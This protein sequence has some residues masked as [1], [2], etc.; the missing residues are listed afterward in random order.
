MLGPEHKVARAPS[1]V[2]TRS[3][4]DPYALPLPACPRPN[5]L[6]LPA[7]AVAIVVPVRRAPAEA[8][9]DT[10]PGN[11]VSAVTPMRESAAELVAPAADAA[12]EVTA[13]SPAAKMASAHA[14]T[15]AAAKVAAT[16]ATKVATTT[17]TTTV[18]CGKRIRRDETSSQH[19]GYDGDHDSVH[20]R[21]LHCGLHLIEFELVR[22][23]TSSEQALQAI[24]QYCRR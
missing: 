12:T 2:I 13:W 11:S 5:M 9:T 10:S 15:T 18:A 4:A 8:P 3:A 20:Q 19:H 6:K 24:A 23:P 21:F 22:L 1:V 7:R 17:A 14:A 16:A